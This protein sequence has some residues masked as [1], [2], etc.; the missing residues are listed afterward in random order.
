MN[1]I[2]KLRKELNFILY[3]VYI[4][5]G[6]YFVF[7]FFLLPFFFA[8]A[9][10][11]LGFKDILDRYFFCVFV[12]FLLPFFFAFAKFGLG[13]KDFFFWREDCFFFSF[14]IGRKP[15]LYNDLIRSSGETPRG[16]VKVGLGLV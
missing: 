13:F 2:Y 15:E 1:I 14:R 8:F 12:F 10:F 9:K 5:P 3:I 7:V 16:M 4:C 11:G 6:T